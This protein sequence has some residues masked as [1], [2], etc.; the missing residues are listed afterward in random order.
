MKALVTGASSGI[1]RDIAINLAKMGIDVVLVARTKSKLIEVKEIIKK[2]YNVDVKIEECD[3]SID[4]NCIK[5]YEN[6]KDIDILINNAG[7]GN[8]GKYEE[9]SLEKDIAIIN[10]NI[11]AVSILT[12]LYLKE[13]KSK[14]NGYI[15]N[16]ASI[17]GFMSGPL[18]ASYYASKNYVVKLSEA[19]REELLKDKSK[20][21]IS[22]LCPGPVKTNFN[23]IAG[24][25][26]ELNSLT[27]DYV[28]KYA[29]KKMFNKKFYIIPGF[30]VK[31]AIFFSKFTPT[32]IISKICYRMQKKK[33]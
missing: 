16:V 1:G 14:N 10:I 30:F 6:N 19:V 25:K 11:K 13:M 26:F 17:A 9:T 27:S 12:K 18:M 20:V 23:N 28:A 7:L 24:V 4:T 33:M 3:V 15:L 8:F 32:F 21:R 2:D 5:L 31:C 22:I 29:I